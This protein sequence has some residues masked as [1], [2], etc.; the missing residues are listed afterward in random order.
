MASLGTN[1]CCWMNLG[2]ISHKRK[3]WMALQNVVSQ[4]KSLC[5]I[6]PRAQA[7]LQINQIKFKQ[8]QYQMNMYLS[9]DLSKLDVIPQGLNNQA[10]CMYSL[11]W[12]LSS[13]IRTVPCQNAWTCLAIR[14]DGRTPL[15][16][17]TRSLIQ[18]Q[19]GNTTLHQVGASRLNATIISGLW[20]EATMYWMV[21]ENL[22]INW[23]RNSKNLWSSDEFYG[24]MNTSKVLVPKKQNLWILPNGL[25]QRLHSWNLFPSS[26]H[27]RRA[28][29][30]FPRMSCSIITP[31]SVTE[32]TK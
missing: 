20:P 18:I 32:I 8:T 5:E 9:L 25:F 4:H 12:R 26:V 1:G 23:Y 15:L 16:W 3:V 7:S 29:F 11:R 17:F 28:M 10:C 22:F 21:T 2:S 30:V 14:V 13:G 27:S 24:N 19:L 6:N 31:G